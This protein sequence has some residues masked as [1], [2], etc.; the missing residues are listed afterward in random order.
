V[1][2]E[3]VAGKITKSY[4][5]TPWGERLSQ[6]KTNTDGSTEDAYYGYNDH[7]DVEDITDSAG[8]SK[9]TYGYTAYGQNDDAESTGIDKPD[10]A[11]PT[12]EPYNAYRYEAKRWDVDS[13]TYDM[14]FRDYSPGLNQ[15]LTRDTYNGAL[16]D[17]DLA[18][19]PFTG[20]RYAFA[21]G[22]PVNLLDLTGH[23]PHG[24]R[25]TDDA[26]SQACHERARQ[27]YEA[28]QV[29]QEKLNDPKLPTPPPGFT[30][31][32]ASMA[33]AISYAKSL[34]IIADYYAKHKIKG[35]NTTLILSRVTV[36]NS[37]G[38]RVPRI[39]GFV[40]SRGLPRELQDSLTSQG[41]MLYKADPNVGDGHAE[42]RAAALKDNIL[43]Q[44]A[45]LGGKIVD[46]HSVYSTNTICG[47]RE[48]AGEINHYIGKD[49]IKLATGDSGFMGDRKI[50][51]SW[52]SW[53]RR[54]WG[55]Q[56]KIQ[57][58]LRALNSG[59][60]SSGGPEEG[61]LGGAGE[62]DGGT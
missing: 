25:P 7:T 19:D 34:Q 60:L 39:V 61:I 10:P 33:G 18:T 31:E 30:N 46:V 24:C 17:V 21:A 14:G 53:Y 22:N 55:R 58:V 13:G 15:F 59:L 9:A 44:E 3:D 23:D 57:L 40:S 52:V 12:K 56:P 49:N 26:A 29:G 16:D 36:E 4:Q 2:D 20:N 51:G 8:D 1:L 38:V 47:E 6:V 43:E 11:D 27:A 54:A 35:G 37:E 45:E 50:T 62:E 42:Y 5:Y 28:G 48:C 32:A 41:V